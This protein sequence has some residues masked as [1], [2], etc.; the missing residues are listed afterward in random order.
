MLHFRSGKRRFPALNANSVGYSQISICSV[1]A[2]LS[3]SSYLHPW[4]TSLL[5]CCLDLGF[6]TVRAC[7][8]ARSHV[9]V[10]VCVCV[11]V[12]V[13][14]KWYVIA[15]TFSLRTWQQLQT[16]VHYPQQSVPQL[17]CPPS[18]CQGF[19][20]QHSKQPSCKMNVWNICEKSYEH[21]PSFK[22]LFSTNLIV[23]NVV[24]LKLVTW[25]GNYLRFFA[26]YCHFCK[27]SYPVVDESSGELYA[28]ID[29]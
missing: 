10:W 2:A 20:P 1:C 22:R 28:V 26:L 16:C 3:V 6:G 12:C 24:I 7:V 5:V 9:P 29:A 21:N 13:W 23:P 15:T 25:Q 4:W 18:D 14:L 8:R 17:L 11:H 19:V 27:P